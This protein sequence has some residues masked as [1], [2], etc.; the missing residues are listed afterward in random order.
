MRIMI[1]EEQYKNVADKL[2]CE[3]AAIKAVAEVESSGSGFLPNSD[4]VILFEPHIFWKELKALGEKPEDHVKG[5][6]D[7]LYPIWGTKPYGKNSEQHPRL[8]RA[9]AIHREA[10][11]MSAS[12]GK[13]QIMGFN[14]S[15]CSYPSIQAFVNAMYN[16]EYDHLL[17]FGNFILNSNID[18]ELRAKQWAQFALYYNGKGYAKNK[19]DV[20]LAAAYKKYST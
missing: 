3:V 17:A 14:W 10:A 6:E 18:D 8:K 20:K 5:N 2:G 1:T 13:F 11:L 19:Y 9:T 4:P 16:S 12:W 7:I 15:K